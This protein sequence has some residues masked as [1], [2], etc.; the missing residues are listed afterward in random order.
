[1]VHYRCWLLENIND[2][3]I[4]SR[5]GGG[6]EGCHGHPSTGGGLKACEANA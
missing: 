4:I 6:G 3:L 1:M 2:M 5:G